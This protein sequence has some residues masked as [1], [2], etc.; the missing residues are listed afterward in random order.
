LLFT[1][2]VAQAVLIELMKQ[3]SLQIVHVVESYFNC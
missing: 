2:V 3:G 1:S